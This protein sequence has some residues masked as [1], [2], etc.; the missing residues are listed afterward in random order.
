MELDLAKTFLEIANA[1]TLG[2]AATR[3]HV[4]Q[5]TVSARLQNLEA[6]VNRKLFVRNKGGARLT[7]AGH[8][9]VPYATQLLQVWQQATQKL[10][11]DQ[12]PALT[13]GGEHSLWSAL[14]LNWL[15]GLRAARPLLT[16]HTQVDTPSNL[17]DG[18]QRGN[19]D[20]AIMYS[21]HRRSGVT[22]ELVL[23]EELIAVSTERCSKL[24]LETYVYVDWG[25]DFESQHQACLPEFIGARTKIGLGPL[26]LRYIL[27]VG[28]SGY[29]RTRAVEP[30]LNSGRLHP[31]TSAPQFLYSLYVAS[32]DASEPD[33]LAWAR[34]KLAEAALV[35]SETWA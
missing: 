5:A 10:A 23:E 18:V 8:A 30:Y 33:L 3:L 24:E 19:I 34:E 2:R 32:S 13:L 12:R 31:V 28:G 27:Q 25:P 7:P 1:G 16:L 29:F 15:I 14:L 6:E 11:E 9:L 21:P 4:T 17:L 35:P 20:A 22:T 26:A